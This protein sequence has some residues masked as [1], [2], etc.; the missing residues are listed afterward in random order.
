MDTLSLVLALEPRLWPGAQASYVI[1]VL[2]W[3]LLP[4]LSFRVPDA[5]EWHPLL[6]PPPPTLTSEQARVQQLL[7]DD[8]IGHHL[9]TVHNGVSRDVGPRPCQEGSGD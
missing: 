4:S 9:S 3:A 7:L 8:V 6:S 2:K 5:S 1:T